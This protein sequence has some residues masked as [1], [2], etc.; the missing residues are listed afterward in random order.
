MSSLR[1]SKRRVGRCPTAETWG[2][3]K[4]PKGGWRKEYG[5][6]SQ[7]LAGEIEENQS[8]QVLPS[9]GCVSAERGFPGGSDGKE[10]ACSAGDLISTPRLGRSSREGNGS[11]LQYSC[12]ENPVNR[13]AWRA[14]VHG[15]AKSWTQLSDF[16]QKVVHDAATARMLVP[17]ESPWSLV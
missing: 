13:G 10:S 4:S 11:P 6:R 9:W 16:L 14:T 17:L 12:P 7:D 2:T 15:V 1:N 5:W 8:P 3:F